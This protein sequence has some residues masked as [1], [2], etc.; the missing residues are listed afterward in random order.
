[1]LAGCGRIGL[2]GLGVALAAAARS[3]C[4]PKSYPSQSCAGVGPLGICWARMSQALILEAQHSQLS[5]SRAVKPASGVDRASQMPAY[6][7]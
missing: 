2:T 4:Y 1:M 6:H 5:D 3:A 7:S